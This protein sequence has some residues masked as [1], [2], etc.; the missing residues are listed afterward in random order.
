M[1]TLRWIRPNQRCEKLNVDAGRSRPRAPCGA[2]GVI[3]R[4]EDGAFL[5]ASTLT[6]AGITDPETMEWRP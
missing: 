2:V 4:S 3:C 5:G 1:S 6:I